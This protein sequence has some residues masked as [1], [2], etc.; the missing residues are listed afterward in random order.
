MNISYYKNRANPAAGDDIANL[1]FYGNDSTA[2]LTEYVRIVPQIE[3]H[4][5][6]SE[7]GMISLYTYKAGVLSERIRYSSADGFYILN[8]GFR[9]ADVYNVNVGGT[10]RS[11]YINSSGI[12][13]GLTSSIRYKENI[14]NISYGLDEVM[15][16]RAV[17]FNYKSDPTAPRSVGFIA[18]E[19]DAIGLKELVSYNE[20]NK[21]E[22]VHYEL[23]TSLLTKAIQE[24]Q[25][26][27]Q[28]QQAMI[29]ALEARITKLGG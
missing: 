2:A 12:F 17:T 9:A 21:P 22:T 3:D 15:Q 24:Q 13:G 23:M 14:E 1:R 7:D 5:N 26:L 27:I 20:E 25:A 6:G 11:A 10:Y 29:E 4:T 16:L 8:G 28:N 18:E 19:V